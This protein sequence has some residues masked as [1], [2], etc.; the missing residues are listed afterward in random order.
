[1]TGRRSV[2]YLVVGGGFY[3]CCLA[4]F[5]RSMS[6]RIM[7]VEAE[8]V[9]LDRA[10]RVNQAR[11]HTGFHYPR[12]MLTAVKSLVLHN[13]FAS[14]FPDAVVD[15]F[16]MLYAIARRRSKVSA[17]RFHRMFTDMGSPI[18]PA[19]ASQ[20]ALFDPDLIEAAFACREYAFDYS[21]LRR[22]MENRFDALGFDIRLGTM[23]SEIEDRGDGAI[24]RLSTG[25]EIHA[26]YIFN[27]T[28]SQ[29]NALLRSAG[30]PEADVKHEVAEIALIKVPPQLDRYGVTIMDG[31]FLS[32]MP[33]P[34][35]R[36]HSLTHVRYTPQLS[37]TDRTTSRSAYDVF[38]DAGLATRHRHMLLDGRRYLP[39]LADAEWLKSIYD[40]KTVMVKNEQDDGR[41]ILFRRQPE[42]SHVISVIGGKIDNIYDLFDAVRRAQPEWTSADLRFLHEGKPNIRKSA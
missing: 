39:C 12:N 37:W 35:E 41:P 13:R 32:C 28:Y 22:H 34:A 9:L 19:N 21:V 8:D 30:L 40:V 33:Y 27:A 14:D 29:V 3:G 1:M 38:R 7:L 31:P 5:L 23:V 17:K 25:E 16:E 4:L 15:D 6:D 10:S 18:A 36:A 20:A 42:G 11:V 26:R 24:A 2:D